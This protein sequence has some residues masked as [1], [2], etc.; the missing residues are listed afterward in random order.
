MHKWFDTLMYI[1]SGYICLIYVLWPSYSPEC[2]VVLSVQWILHMEH[3]NS[4]PPWIRIM[5]IQG[6]T[7]CPQHYA[8]LNEYHCPVVFI[9][10]IAQNF[11][12]SLISW[13]FNRLHNYFNEIFWH[14]NCSFHVQKCQWTR[15]RGYAAK[16]ALGPPQIRY[17]WSRH[18]FAD[19]CEL[20][21]RQQCDSAC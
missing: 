1:N 12:G 17:L 4:F 20:K 13:I 14:L 11:R 21:C 19:S 9:Y 7:K 10:R 8:G 16:S 2:C 18:C 15:S 6:C 3:H 5:W